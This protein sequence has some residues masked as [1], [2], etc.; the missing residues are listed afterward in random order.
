MPLHVLSTVDRSAE[1]LLTERT[2]VRLHAHVCGHVPREAA[3]GCERGT[4]DAA[5]ECLDTYSDRQERVREGLTPVSSS[6]R[7]LRQTDL[8]QQSL[9]GVQVMT[10]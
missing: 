2:L 6:H 7:H 10:F 5:A 9:C 8:E 1:A 3:I 4:A